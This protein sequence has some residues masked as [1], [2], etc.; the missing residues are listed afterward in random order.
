MT[1][2]G[3]GEVSHEQQESY[4]L[5]KRKNRKGKS[6]Y[7]VRFIDQQTGKKIKEWASGETAKGAAGRAAELELEKI[8]EQVKEAATL[9]SLAEGF[10]NWDATNACGRRARGKS[11]AHG[12]L[13]TAESNTRLHTRPVS[14][15]G[16]KFKM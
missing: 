14:G 16:A 2:L 13:D 1:Y 3:E 5:I 8:Q 10:W 7:Y 6:Q 12:T 9:G 15:E 11:I 4:Y